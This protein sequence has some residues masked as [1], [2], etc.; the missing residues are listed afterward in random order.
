M[1]DSEQ[2]RHHCEAD[3]TS[4]TLATA[5]LTTAEQTAR[6]HASNISIQN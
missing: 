1:I 2:K 4:N 5:K 3:M 6:T